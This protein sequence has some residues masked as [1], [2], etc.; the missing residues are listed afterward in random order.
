MGKHPS[1]FC[2][3][4]HN[5]R[6]L[7]QLLVEIG[8]VEGMRIVDGGVEVGALFVNAIL[9]DEVLIA[10][11][12][13]IVFIARDFRVDLWTQTRLHVEEVEKA[14]LYINPITQTTIL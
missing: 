7:T 10:G 13:L 11:R 2:P 3:L 1:Y 9:L 12:I 5:C 4:L 6:S 8:G 14:R